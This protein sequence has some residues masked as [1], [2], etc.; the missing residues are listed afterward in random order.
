M[1]DFEKALKKKVWKLVEDIS[2]GEKH[3]NDDDFINGARWAHDLMTEELKTANI[4]NKSLANRNDNLKAGLALAV[5]AIKEITNTTRL[6]DPDNHLADHLKCVASDA[7]SR[8]NQAEGQ[9][10][11]NN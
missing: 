8:I 5:S 6:N 2:T 4:I 10:D 11:R 1:D 7:L 9:H 3:E